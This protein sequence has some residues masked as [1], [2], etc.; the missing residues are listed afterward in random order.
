[1]AIIT[2]NELIATLAQKNTKITDNLIYSLGQQIVQQGLVF[3]TDKDKDNAIELLVKLLNRNLDP[4][5]LLLTSFSKE[6][7]TEKNLI[8]L[9]MQLTKELMKVRLET[10]KEFCLKLISNNTS[11]RSHI[12]PFVEFV[13][14]YKKEVEQNEVTVNLIG[15]VSVS[16]P[17]NTTSPIIVTNVPSSVTDTQNN[18]DAP[19]VTDN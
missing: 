9:I 12:K 18:S 13:L 1:M 15:S 11:D 4:F 17:H 16:I 6:S 2:V 3:S 5:E 7:N 19:I 10:L 8:T 14:N